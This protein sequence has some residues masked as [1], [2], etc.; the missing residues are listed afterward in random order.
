MKPGLL[1]LQRLGR[2]PS[3]QLV[4]QAFEGVEFLLQFLAVSIANHWIAFDA[5]DLVAQRTA[6]GHAAD[7]IAKVPLLCRR[8]IDNDAANRFP[9]IW[10][11]HGTEIKPL[12][13]S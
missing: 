12:S 10:A 11:N 7:G 1:F 6:V 9:A 5:D 13:Q 3:H 4:N 2:E 8:V